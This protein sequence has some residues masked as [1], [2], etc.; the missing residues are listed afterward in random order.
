VPNLDFEVYEGDG[1]EAF[2]LDEVKERDDLT[3]SAQYLVEHVVTDEFA[4][5][6]LG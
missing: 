5:Q 4:A 2:S 1:A 3:S 6:M